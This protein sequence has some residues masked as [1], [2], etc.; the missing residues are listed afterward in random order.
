MCGRPPVCED[1]SLDFRRQA[2]LRDLPRRSDIADEN[3]RGELC[4]YP[5]RSLAVAYRAFLAANPDRVRRVEEVRHPAQREAFR[6]DESQVIADLQRRIAELQESKAS[7]R[8]QLI[9][10]EARSTEKPPGSAEANPNDLTDLNQRVIDAIRRLEP[11][12]A[13]LEHEVRERSPVRVTP[14]P[15]RR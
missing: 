8:S 5:E 11:R 13:T 10:S 7:L 15:S 2:R 3:R 1:S 14:D 9:G 4:G 12:L 6:K